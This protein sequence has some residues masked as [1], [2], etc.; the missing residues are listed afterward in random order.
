MTE[1]I[2]IGIFRLRGHQ[3]MG[4]TCA[5]FKF[6]EKVWLWDTLMHTL[7]LESVVGCTLRSLTRQRDAHWGV[8]LCGVHHTTES[9][10]FE[11][12]CFHLFYWKTS[13]VEE[14]PQTSCDFQY[15]FHSKILRH[16]REIIIVKVRIK[17]GTYTESAVC[18]L[19]PWYDAHKES[20]SAVWCRPRSFLYTFFH[21]YLLWWTPLSLTLQYDAQRGVKLQGVMHTTELD[22]T[23]WC[24]TQ[25]QTPRYDAHHRAWLHSM[26]HTAELFKNLNISAKLKPNSKILYPVYQGPRRVQIMKKIEFKNLVTH[27]L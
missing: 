13:E 19:N 9:D 12:V 8:W 14:I 25:S 23:V 2:C 6:K 21:D 5:C 26:M 16:H 18:S 3:G 4:K 20:Y 1:N 10:Y 11:N 17:T 7:E 24:T 27:S 15:N 22:S